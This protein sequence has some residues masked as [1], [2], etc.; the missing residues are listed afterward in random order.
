KPLRRAVEEDIRRGFGQAGDRLRADFPPTRQVINATAQG[1]GHEL[2]AVADAKQRQVDIHGVP[3]PGGGALAPV[4][5]FGDHGA[6]AGD[7]GASCQAGRGQLLAGG[8]VD[9]AH[10]PGRQSRRTLEPL[11][12]IAVARADAVR[13]AAGADDQ[14]G[15]HG[16][17]LAVMAR[18]GASSKPS[19]GGRTPR[20]SCTVVKPRATCEAA[21]MRSGRRPSA[22]AAWPNSPRSSVALIKLRKVGESIIIS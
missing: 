9:D 2:V 20:I 13:R 15:F 4:Q 21:E 8:D 3:E 16:W 19:T 12:E 1:M 22:S 6:G 10:A 5:A 11:R 7:D 14:Y 18:G 17:P